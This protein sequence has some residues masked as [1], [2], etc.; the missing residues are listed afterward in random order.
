[1]VVHD[2]RVANARPHD[3]NSEGDALEEAFSPYGLVQNV[4]LVKDKGGECPASLLPLPQR[5]NSPTAVVQGGLP[6]DRCLR[7]SAPAVAYIKFPLASSAA[8]AIESLNG[9]VLNDGRGPK[10]KVMLAEV[11]TPRCASARR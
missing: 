5:S 10:L 7:H 8:L 9:A 1:M 3:A 6:P 2:R 4:K 11:P